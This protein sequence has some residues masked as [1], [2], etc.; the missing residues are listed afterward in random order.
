MTEKT[1]KPDRGKA[2]FFDRLQAITEGYLTGRKRV[3][4]I[5]KEKQQ[6]K[7]PVLDWLEAFV[8]AAGMVL[9]INQYLFQAYQIPSGSMI[10]TLLIGDRVF[11]NKIIFGPELLPGVMKLPSPVKPR[12]NDVIIF[13]NPSYSSLGPAFDIAQRV[14]YMLTLSIVD[15]DRDE[16]GQPKAHFLIKRAVGWG[17]DQIT[18]EQGELRI[19]FAGESRWVAERDFNAGRGFH[20]RISRI[21]D[22]DGYPALEARGKIMAYRELALAP[23]D[24]LESAAA[25]VSAMRYPD[26]YAYDRARLEVL[27][28]AQP[29]KNQYRSSY[30]AR[31]V[32]GWYV[33][34]GRILP[35]GDNRDNSRDGRYFG[36][37]R[38]AKV[39]G[40][41][42][43][44]Y[45]PLGRLSPIR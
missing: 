19:R 27:R 43:I 38:E 33:P 15:I 9:L 7:N 37:I 4:R 16:D 6:A 21:M 26:L 18:Q 17:G 24:S 25:P 28:G 31:Y 30:H 39:L 40:K 41:G 44:I 36:A 3:R 29:Q 12:R 5:K 42:F 1:V 23:P 8:W 13:E 35:L 34:E 2:D 22:K 14:I 11:V 20:H 45:W 32:R 10:D